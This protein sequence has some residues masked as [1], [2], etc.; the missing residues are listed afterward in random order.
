MA[1]FTHL[2]EDLKRHASAMRTHTLE[3]YQ[4]S[5][6]AVNSLPQTTG[7][8]QS[9]ITCY[10]G[11]NMRELWTLS[12]IY[13]RAVDCGFR[14]PADPVEHD[15]EVALYRAGIA[16][17]GAKKPSLKRRLMMERLSQ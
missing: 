3:Q 16:Y 15:L 8:I 17:Y 7:V 10:N 9:L 4:R 11:M 14:A 6:E 1:K 12:L 5:L 13:K 2:R